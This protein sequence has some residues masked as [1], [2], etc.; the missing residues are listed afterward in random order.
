MRW[1]K[2]EKLVIGGFVSIMLA[3]IVLLSW[4][5]IYHNCDTKVLDHYE[6]VTVVVNAVKVS[7]PVAVLRCQ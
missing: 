4:I 1:S 2:G 5:A 6:Y 3:L 7:V